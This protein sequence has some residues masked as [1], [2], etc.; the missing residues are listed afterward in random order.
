MPTITTLSLAEPCS[1]CNLHPH[2]PGWSWTQEAGSVAACGPRGK[3][4]EGEMGNG[5]G[6]E[7]LLSMEGKPWGCQVRGDAYLICYSMH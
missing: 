1:P 2:S 4:R 7:V 3:S 5:R 6:G